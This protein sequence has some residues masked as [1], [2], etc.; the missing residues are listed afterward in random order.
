[1]Q[2]TALIAFYYLTYLLAEVT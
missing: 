1:M 2:N